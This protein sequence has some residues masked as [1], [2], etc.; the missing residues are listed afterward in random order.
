M[1]VG[2]PAV[3]LPSVVPGLPTN[4]PE[5]ALLKKNDQRGVAKVAVFA[6]SRVTGRALWQSGTVEAESR[7]HDTWVF[8]AGPIS[9]GS[10]RRRTELAGEPLPSLPTVFGGKAPEP[11][12]PGPASEQFFPNYQVPPPPPVVPAGVLGVTGAAVVGEKPVAR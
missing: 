8:G 2:T 9:R 11:P 7:L 3:Q 1:L 5:I 10:I 6:Y 4:L 12:P